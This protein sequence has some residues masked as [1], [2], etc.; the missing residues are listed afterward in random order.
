[1]IY[2]DDGS[3]IAYLN[4]DAVAW[5]SASWSASD[6]SSTLSVEVSNIEGSV[7]GYNHFDKALLMACLL[8]LYGSR[9]ACML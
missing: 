7:R 1:M 4:D 5:T 6:D 9:K 2:E 3:T 8:M